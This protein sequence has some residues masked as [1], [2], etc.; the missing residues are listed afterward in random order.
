M[1]QACCS[2]VPR[3]PEEVADLQNKEDKTNKT[4]GKE[5]ER[6]DIMVVICSREAEQSRNSGRRS[7]YSC[8]EGISHRTL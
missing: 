4:I 1:L 6:R 5:D 2:V 3:T 8:S 7:R